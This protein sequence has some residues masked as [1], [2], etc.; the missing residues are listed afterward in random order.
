M[1]DKLRTGR[2]KK[3]GGSIQDEAA[4]TQELVMRGT[5][6]SKMGWKRWKERRMKGSRSIGKGERKMRGRME[7][8]R[9][10]Q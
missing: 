9:K 3:G 5:K 7:E 4:R 6:K 10:G 8:L 1:W 2:A